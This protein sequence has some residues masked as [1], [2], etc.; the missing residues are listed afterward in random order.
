MLD[1]E[2][3]VEKGEERE[4]EMVQQRAWDRIQMENQVQGRIQN[5]ILTGEKGP[6]PIFGQ[7][8]TFKFYFERPIFNYGSVCE[9][10]LCIQYIIII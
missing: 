8:E 10:L 5:I 1:L 4:R 7:K 3:K 6:P 2:K 9:H